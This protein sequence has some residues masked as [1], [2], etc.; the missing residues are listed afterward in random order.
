MFYVGNLADGCVASIRNVTKF[1]AGKTDKCILAFFSHELCHGTCGTNKLCAFSGIKLYVVD[2]STNGDVGKGKSV[3]GDDVCFRTGNNFIAGFH[4]V[5]S[6]DVSLLAVFILNKSDVCGTVGVVLKSENVCHHSGF[7]T[8][9][10]D[11]TIFGSVAAA[12]MTNGDAAVG[13]T[14]GMLLHRFEKAAFRSY[15][16]KSRIIDGGH[17]ATTGSSGVIELNSHSVRPPYSILSKNSM[18]LESALRVTIAFFQ[19]AVLP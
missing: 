18:P 15:L 19:S 10:I 11:Y 5:R 13:V 9:E 1:A 12:T 16:G 4:S 8:F 14:T 6:N 17:I 2:E 3:A 7:V